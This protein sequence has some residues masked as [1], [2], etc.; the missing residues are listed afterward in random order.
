MNTLPSIT[1]LLSDNH[2][3]FAT[4][5]LALTRSLEDNF[6]LSRFKLDFSVLTTHEKTPPRHRMSPY[7]TGCLEVSFKA[8]HFPSR[9]CRQF[10]ALHLQLSAR[11]VQVWFQ[12]KRQ[13]YRTHHIPL[14]LVSLV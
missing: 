9:D 4:E 11:K 7:Q 5:P 8:S 12:N 6:Q 13:K 2:A 10:M 1:M 14:P 3:L